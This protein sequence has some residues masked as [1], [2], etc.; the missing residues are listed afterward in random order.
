MTKMRALATALLLFAG[1]A[2]SL[3]GMGL[4]VFEETTALALYSVGVVSGATWLSVGTYRNELA[5]KAQTKAPPE[6]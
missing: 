4:L 6:G 5:D 3:V 1:S 2:G